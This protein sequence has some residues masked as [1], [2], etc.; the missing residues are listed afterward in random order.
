MSVSRHFL[1]NRPNPLFFSPKNGAIKLMSKMAIFGM[2][3]WQKLRVAS[4]GTCETAMRLF[5]S[6][7]ADGFILETSTGRHLPST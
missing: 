2:A 4:T 6:Q 5:R 3:P 1:A 7:G